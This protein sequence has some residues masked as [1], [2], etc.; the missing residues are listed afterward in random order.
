MEITT[1]VVAGL[2]AFLVNIVMA[3]FVYLKNRERARNKLFA[4]LCLSIGV[5]CLY[6]ATMNS[7]LDLSTKLLFSRIIY[8]FASFGPTLYLHFVIEMLNEVKKQKLALYLSYLFSLVFSFLCFSSFFMKGLCPSNTY[9]Y[10]IVPG[11]LYNVFVGGFGVICIYGF[12]LL[13]NRYRFSSGFQRN[14]Y[15]Y[16]FLSCFLAYA[17]GLMH[18]ANVYGIKE[19]FPHDFFLI[20]FVF[21]NAYTIVKYRLMDIRIVFRTVLTYSVMTAFVALFF[22][23]AIY[24]PARLF[25]SINQAASFLIILLISFCFALVFNP[26]RKRIEDIFVKLFYP[27]G[28]THY[29]EL[30]R[31]SR[32]L[33]TILEV[34]VLLN[35]IIEKAVQSLAASLGYLYI[36]KEDK[37]IYECKA[38]LPEKINCPQSTLNT[39]HILVTLLKERKDVLL[40]EDLAIIPS[41]LREKLHD[42][43]NQL[44]IK[45]VLPMIFRDQMVGFLCL[46]GKLSGDIYTSLDIHLLSLF[47]DEA[48]IA[49]ENAKLFQQV[50]N[51]SHYNEV[52]LQGMRSGVI[53]LDE[54]G[55]ISAFNL[56][57]EKI[58][59]LSR[60]Y[61]MGKRYSVLPSPLD[62][63]FKN[64]YKEKVSY[65]DLEFQLDLNGKK[66]RKI[67]VMINTTLLYDEMNGSQIKQVI[68]VLT[69]LTRVKEL[70]KEVRRAEKLATMGTIAGELAHEIKN[71]LVS[72]KTLAQLLPS[73]YNDQEFRVKFMNVALKEVDRINERVNKLLNLSIRNENKRHSRVNIKDLLEETLED[74]SIQLAARKI[75]VFKNYTFKPLILADKSELKKAFSNIIIN[76]IEAVDEE[77]HILVNVEE[78]KNSPLPVCVIFRDTGP[79]FSEESLEKALDVFYTTKKKGSGLGLFLAYRVVQSHQG[80]IKV[81]NWEKG[82]EVTVELPLLKENQQTDG[83]DGQIL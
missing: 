82:A 28:E 58:T 59:G 34:D 81:R 15:K 48:S 2:S 74:L 57:A 1:F 78:R 63:L 4:L 49:L 40:E 24:P 54:S 52:I 18:F 47:L 53:S 17:G 22:L 25:G 43:F 69:D 36:L 77:G 13:A 83:K 39:D 56:Q 50:K 70:E 61:V 76:S 73:K 30:T 7:Y 20:A 35:F 3:V 80:R 60:E 31:Y 41:G 10:G 37:G 11:F 38:K 29:R 44:Q 68:S 66:K 16:L 8:V 65:N 79:G 23:I 32:E 33:A 14:Q 71:P 75:K 67:P 51:M 27:Q 62:K 5:W 64:V 42:F 9:R 46:G 6:P 26:L 55:K 72:I 21:T 45:L 19:Y 12:F